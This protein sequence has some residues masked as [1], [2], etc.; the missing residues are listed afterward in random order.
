MLVCL[1]WHPWRLLSGLLLE[2][3]GRRV[4]LGLRW[5]PRRQRLLLLLLLLLGL[6]WLPR[7]QRLLLLVV[8]LLVLL[9][10]VLLVLLVVL[11]LV[12]LQVLTGRRRTARLRLEKSHHGRGKPLWHGGL[13]A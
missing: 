12:L 13:S 8:L 4:L 2:I 5:L 7:R 10:V 11:R 6:R 3:V 9:L 1:C